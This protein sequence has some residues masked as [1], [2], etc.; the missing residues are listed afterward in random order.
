MITE[1]RKM[2]SQINHCKLYIIKKSRED[3]RMNQ[4]LVSKKHLE[5]KH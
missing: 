2:R 4:I 3:M 5:D 1:W